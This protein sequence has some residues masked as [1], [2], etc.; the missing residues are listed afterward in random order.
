MISI[1]EVVDWGIVPYSRVVVAADQA[2]AVA[3]VVA[4]SGL[5]AAVGDSTD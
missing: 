5:V 3:A 4:F 1:D 2:A